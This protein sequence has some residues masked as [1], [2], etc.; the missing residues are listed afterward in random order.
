VATYFLKLG[1]FRA[2]KATSAARRRLQR[3]VKVATHLRRKHRC[4]DGKGRQNVIR[5]SINY[6]IETKEEKLDC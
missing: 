2:L 3:R 6:V 1:P 4:N 5:K